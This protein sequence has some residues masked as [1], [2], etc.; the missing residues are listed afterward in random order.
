M[1][2]RA[3]APV[4]RARETDDCHDS[5]NALDTLTFE[6]FEPRRRTPWTRNRIRQRLIDALQGIAMTVATGFSVLFLIAIPAAITAIS[7]GLLGCSLARE[8]FRR[9]KNPA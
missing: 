9:H 1:L 7:L 4:N 6:K 3:H 8:T 5:Y 2:R